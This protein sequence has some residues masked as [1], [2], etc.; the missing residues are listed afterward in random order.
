[1][2]KKT[3]GFVFYS[4]PGHGWL[5]VPK[6]IVGFLSILGHECISEFSYQSKNFFFLEEDYDMS[7][8]LKAYKE[9]FGL[10]AIISKQ[11]ISRNRESKIRLNERAI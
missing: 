2:K 1:M 6:G 10:D 4:D 11:V 9:A 5:R 7:R 3:N 8:F